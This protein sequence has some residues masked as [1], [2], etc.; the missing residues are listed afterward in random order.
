MKN[1]TFLIITIILLLITGSVIAGILL[2]NHDKSNNDS[3]YSNPEDEGIIQNVQADSNGDA[4]G[5]EV[6]PVSSGCGCGG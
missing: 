2:I 3:Y 6:T 1:K 4:L 5:N